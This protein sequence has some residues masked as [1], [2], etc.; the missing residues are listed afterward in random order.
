MDWKRPEMLLFRVEVRAGRRTG[1][2]PRILF[3][4]LLK[5]RRKPKSAKIMPD[6][7]SNKAQAQVF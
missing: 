3:R 6:G 5:L 2:N 4:M 1:R 7:M